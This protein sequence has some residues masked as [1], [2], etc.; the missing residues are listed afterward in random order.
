MGSRAEGYWTLR[1]IKPLDVR[2]GIAEQGYVIP[3]SLSAL[4]K[5]DGRSVE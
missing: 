2:R 5:G 3:A 4:R 1:R